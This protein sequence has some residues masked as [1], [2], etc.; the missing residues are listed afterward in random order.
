LFEV[1]F[2]NIRHA[3]ELDVL[4]AGEQVHDGLRAASA[5]AHQ[6]GLQPVVG[7]GPR[8]ADLEDGE[9]GRPG[10]KKASA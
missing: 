8:F 9:G 7:G 5:A 6:A 1:I 3:G 4:V 2:E 10:V